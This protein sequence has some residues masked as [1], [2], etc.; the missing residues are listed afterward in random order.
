M[1]NLKKYILFTFFVAFVNVFVFSQT[2]TSQS[3][4]VESSVLDES[5]ILLGETNPESQITFSDDE[6]NLEKSSVWLFVRMILV[7]I[8]VIVAIYALMKF[9]KKKST[10]VKSSDDFLRS[11]S[12]LSFGPG[13]SV[14]IVTLIDKAYVLGVTEK[15]INLIAE[16]DDKEL[17][18]SLN[19]N[20]DKKSNVSKPINF[21]EVLDMFVNPK[22]KRK[23]SVLDDETEKTEEG[24]V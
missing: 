10:E 24:S 15:S 21:A 12:S 13:K 14:E 3:S 8:L 20:H 6:S 9:F 22:N 23:A 16:I 7:L 4:S 17:I 18:E 19:L 5:Q 1:G 2:D 11:V